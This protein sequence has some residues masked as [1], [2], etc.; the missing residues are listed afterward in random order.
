MHGMTLLA[1]VTLLYAG[2]NLFVKFSGEHVPATTTSTVVATICLQ[3]AALAASVVFLSVQM[4][5][6]GHTFNLS[7]SSYGWA[8]AAGLCI[9]CAEIGYFYLFSGVGSEKAM[10]ASVVIPTVVSGE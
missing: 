9:G 10:P 6:G 7:A 2:Y 1:A 8:I 5:R 4:F 3:V